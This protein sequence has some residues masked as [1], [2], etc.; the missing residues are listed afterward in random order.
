MSRGF[1]YAVTRTGVTG[2][3]SESDSDMLDYLDGVRR[4]SPIPVLAGFGI[5]AASQVRAVSAHADGVIVGSALID[6][7]DKGEDAVA[8]LRALRE[9][10]DTRLE[11]HG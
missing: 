6:V 4:L 2:A 9:E 10:T 3:G 7:L 1:V 11:A 5:R 8:F